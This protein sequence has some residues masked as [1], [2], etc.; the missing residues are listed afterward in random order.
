MSLLEIEELSIEFGLAARTVTVVDR[1]SFAVNRGETLGIVGESGSGKSLTLR[2]I[3]HILPGRARISTGSIRFDG[4]DVTRPSRSQLHMLRGRGIT[5]I[6]QDPVSALN[7]VVTVEQQ[8]R[9]VLGQAEGLRG[10]AARR[11]AIDLLRLVEVPDPGRV[12]ACFAHELSGGL[13]QRVVIAIALSPQPRVL[14][15]DEPTTALDVTVQAQ[16]L[17]L[18]SDLRH[19]LGMALVLVTHD[20]G[21]VAQTCDRVAVM[22]AGRVVEMGEINDVFHNP[23]HPYTVGLLASMPGIKA[24]VRD[25]TLFAMPGSPPEFGSDPEGCAFRRRCPL[26]VAACGAGVIPLA[27][28]STDHVAACI[29]SARVRSEG[30]SFGVSTALAGGRVGG[31]DAGA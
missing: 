16:I 28:V 15:A 24:G 4:Q 6:L 2:A 12:L 29:R 14:L 30:V 3:L 17:R 25:R 23:G 19:R 11:R 13:A 21:V 26:A 27:A 10:D 9:E 5:M 20:M 18:I 7:P 31:D 22:Y 8:F 1:V